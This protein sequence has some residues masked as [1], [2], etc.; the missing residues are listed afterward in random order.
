M[1]ENDPVAASA[2]KFKPMQSAIPGTTLGP[3]QINA[4]LRGGVC[5]SIII[6]QE[7]FKSSTVTFYFKQK[8]YDTP[9]VHLHHRQASSSG[10]FRRSTCS[11]SSKSA[12]GILRC[13]LEMEQQGM[14]IPMVRMAI[15]YSE[16]VLPE[17]Q[18]TFYGPKSLQIHMVPSDKADE[19]YQKE[20]GV[21]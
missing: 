15:Q 9:E 10:S 4:F 5:H 8:L 20:L 18:L 13:P 3:I 2:Q 17:T 11:C 21:L 16:E 12:K 1:A 7:L 14:T 6:Y 19:F